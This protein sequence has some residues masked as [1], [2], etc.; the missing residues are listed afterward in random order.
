M[1]KALL[2]LALVCAVPALSQTAKVVVL[3]SEESAEANAIAQ[4][5]KDLDKRSDALRDKIEA[6]YLYLQMPATASVCVGNGC[7]P[8]PPP[9]PTEEQKLAARSWLIGWEYGFEFSEDYKAIVPKKGPSGYYFAPS[10]SGVITL[11]CCNA[12]M[13][14][15]PCYMT[16]LPWTYR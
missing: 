5:R 13:S 11:P 8:P 4:A 3:S 16:E 9:A 10:S 12:T 1:R 15:S 2:S 14:P 7:I 6:K